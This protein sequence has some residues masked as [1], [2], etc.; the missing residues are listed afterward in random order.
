MFYRDRLGFEQDLCLK[1][2][3]GT[4]LGLEVRMGI[5]NGG[6]V[7]PGSIA[8]RASDTGRA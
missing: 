4:F 2:D 5:K 6:S 7:F 1:D 8:G 3:N